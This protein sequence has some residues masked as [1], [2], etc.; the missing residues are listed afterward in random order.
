MN[1]TL[2]VNSSNW[3]NVPYDPVQYTP[4]EITSRKTQY[5]QEHISVLTKTTVGLSSR[6][7]QRP[8]EKHSILTKV[9]GSLAR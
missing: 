1:T 6:T 7:Y 8:H 4:H 5:S 2:T 9:Q 3:F